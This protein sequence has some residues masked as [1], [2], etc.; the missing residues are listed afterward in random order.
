M[1]E[2]SDVPLASMTS[3]ALGGPAKRVVF[4]ES[5]RDI[6]ACITAAD[7][8]QEPVLLLGGGSNLVISDEGFP[9]TVLAIAS[10]GVS[11]R[12]DGADVLVDA[13][14][15]EPWDELVVRACAEGHAGLE[16]LSGIPGRVGATPMQ[17]VGAYGADVSAVIASVTAFDRTRGAVVTLDNGACGF[18]YRTSMFR[19]SARYA[20][21]RVT[22]RLRKSGFS[23]P[24]AYAELARA[25]GVRLGETAAIERVRQTVIALRKKKGMVLDADDPESVSAGSFFTNPIVRAHDV[26]GIEARASL[27]RSESMP[28]WPS[29]TPGH[30]A[31]RDAGGRAV[32]E[33]HTKLSAGWLI[34]RAGFAKGHV[35]GSAA[36]STKHALALVNRGGSTR[37]LVALAVEIRNGVRARFG[38]SL[39]PEPIFVGVAW[40]P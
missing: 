29:A 14:A 27:A 25:L 12:A 31:P 7:A 8:A 6:R 10:R 37:A 34:E 15:G 36:I 38:V 1:Q 32:D 17:N 11:V 28:Q 9:G 22:F 33:P 30:D 21:L 26:L 23:A 18:G 20:V 40:P 5:E 35:R 39:T 24:I 2:K 16:C 19:G 3:L 13:E 4:A